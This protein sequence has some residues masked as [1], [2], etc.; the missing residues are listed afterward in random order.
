MYKIRK[1]TESF[2]SHDFFLRG[3]ILQDYLF[4]SYAMC[5]W[6]N[7]SL[8]AAI[9]FSRG[10][11]FYQ[12]LLLSCLTSSQNLKTIQQKIFQNYFTRFFYADRTLADNRIMCYLLVKIL[13][14][15]YFTL[16][17]TIFRS[18]QEILSYYK[19]TR[20][21]LNHWFFIKIKIRFI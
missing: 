8:L 1:Y 11:T 10:S 15:E 4:R 16:L 17:I 2:L 19:I 20:R 12:R 21:L 3:L 14:W 9:S 5:I 6:R 7:S 18:K 13:K